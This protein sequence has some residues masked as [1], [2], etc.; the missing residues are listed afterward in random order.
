MGGLAKLLRSGELTMVWVSDERHKAMRDSPPP[1]APPETWSTAAVSP[2]LAAI[3][4]RH[5]LGSRERDRRD[6]HGSH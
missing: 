6:W 5:V 1:K 2:R 3:G 4:I